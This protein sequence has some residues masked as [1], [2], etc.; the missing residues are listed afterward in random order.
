M[1][2]GAGGSTYVAATMI[3]RT[4]ITVDSS[5]DWL[6][7][8]K[9]FCV[10]RAA[11][12]SPSTIHVDIGPVGDWGFPTDPGTREQW[13]SYYEAPW[14]SLAGPDLALGS[15]A[16]DEI[17][18]FLVD[19]RFRVACFMQIMLRC[20]RDAIIMI[21]DFATRP[22]YHALH[23]VAREIAR[24]GELS[25]FVPMPGHSKHR[26]HELLEEFRFDNR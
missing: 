1:E 23:E 11:P 5:T 6:Q 14:R 8:V 12:I 16:A 17:D 18:L 24:S 26:I 22:Y 7:K 3:K 19:G 21:H 4:V 25:A 9:Q 15:V 13:P 20:R 10:D 2:F